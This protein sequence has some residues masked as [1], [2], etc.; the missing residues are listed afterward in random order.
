MITIGFRI[1]GKRVK[2]NFSETATLKDVYDFVTVNWKGGDFKLRIPRPP[3]TLP[4]ND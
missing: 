1:A 2:W 3:K 4:N